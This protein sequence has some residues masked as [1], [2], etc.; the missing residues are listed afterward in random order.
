MSIIIRVARPGDA[1]FITE[2]NRLMALET[3]S[4]E[5]NVEVLQ[6]GVN[7]LLNDASK[8]FYLLAE[9]TGEIIGQL[10]ITYEWSDW[11]N[12]NIWWIQS[13]YVKPEFRQK[14]VYNS[15]YHQT[16]NLAYAEGVREIRLYVE[17]NNRIAQAVYEKCG[18]NESHYLLYEAKLNK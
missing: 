10:M 5:L 4:I 16:K 18:M 17:K 8:G 14:G 15:L 12:R 2:F 1:S 9:N 7:N 13:V 3:E 6:Q 11:R